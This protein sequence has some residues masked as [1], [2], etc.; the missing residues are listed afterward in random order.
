MRL[1]KIQNFRV[2][3]NKTG[4]LFRESD[5]T[6]SRLKN[7]LPRFNNLPR[8]SPRYWINRRKLKLN[9]KNLKFTKNTIWTIFEQFLNE[10]EWW[11]LRSNDIRRY[12]NIKFEFYRILTNC[13]ICH[14]DPVALISNYKFALWRHAHV[15]VAWSY[16]DLP[17]LYLEFSRQNCHFG[18]CVGGYG[19]TRWWFVLYVPSEFR[20]SGWPWRGRRDQR[21][22]G[23]WRLHLAA[24]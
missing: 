10:T 12:Q 8:F 17:S 22:R 18:R 1:K 9:L 14:A 19:Q 2:P 13:I 20:R 5:C 21:T 16:L 11:M 6:F 7:E 4:C 23:R 24:L 3:E 15:V